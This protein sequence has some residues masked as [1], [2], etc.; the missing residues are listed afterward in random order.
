MASPRRKWPKASLN[1]VAEIPLAKA[2]IAKSCKNFAEGAKELQLNLVNGEMPHEWDR[3][4][5]LAELELG[6][7]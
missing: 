3:R 6:Q 5:A 1:T 4:D 7:K 2:S